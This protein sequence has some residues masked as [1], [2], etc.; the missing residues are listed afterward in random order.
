MFTVRM[1]RALRDRI[2]RV[3]RA[4]LM[5]RSDYVRQVMERALRAAQRDK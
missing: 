5:T 4:K 2:D 3:A 1:P